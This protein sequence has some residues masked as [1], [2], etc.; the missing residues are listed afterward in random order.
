M[1]AV[2]FS[3]PQGEPV[4][5]MWTVIFTP[6]IVE[7]GVLPA[8]G[9]LADLKERFVYSQTAS[10]NSS[11]YEEAICRVLEGPAIQPGREYI[12]WFA[13]AEEKPVEVRLSV[14]PI[15]KGILRQKGWALAFVDN[16][17]MAQVPLL[18]RYG[19][20][21]HGAEVTQVALSPDGRRVASVGKD[22][23]IKHWDVESGELLATYRGDVAEFSPDGKFLATTGAGEEVTSVILWDAKGGNK[24]RTLTGGHFLGV[25][26]LA[27]SRDG[28]RL[29]SGGRDGWVTLWDPQ[30]GEQV[31]AP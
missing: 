30:T 12:V 25:C 1:D 23:S 29:V 24:L 3:I 27:F 18:A 31:R 21:Y 19:L 10:W 26:S 22:G 8:A 4:D 14:N 28:R 11:S 2:R 6:E 17:A 5:L 16:Q 7:C 15:P 9:Q 20:F 13:L